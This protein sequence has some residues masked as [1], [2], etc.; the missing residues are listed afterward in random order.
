MLRSLIVA[1]L[2]LIPIVFYGLVAMASG[3]GGTAGSLK[4]SIFGISMMSGGRWVFTVGDFLLLVG[5]VTLFIE[6]LK[7]ARTKSDAII[8]HSFSMLLL[9]VSVISFLVV[10]GFGTS[11]FF[12]LVIMCL[13]DVVAG[14]IV[15]IIAARRDFGVGEEI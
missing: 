11:V 13:L 6:I 2:L 15:S 5:L 12:L 14:P 4:S 7:A 10:P 8:N 3:E 1:P 9:L